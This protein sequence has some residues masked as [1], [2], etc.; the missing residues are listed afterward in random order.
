MDIEKLAKIINDGN[1]AIVPTD[2]VYG[3]IGDA[4]NERAIKKVYNI[5]KRKYSKPLIIMVSSLDMLYEYTK[6]IN[7]KEKELINKFWPGKLTILLPK[8]DKVSNLITAGGPLVGVRYANNK[9]L[10]DLMNLINK[11]LISTSAN[12]ADEKTITSIDMLE[13]DIINNVAYIYDTGKIENAS[14]TIVRVIDGK[15]NILR[16]GDLAKQIKNEY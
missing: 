5:K 7:E 8:N 1:L 11:P 2:T 14:S 9:P 16:E 13:E 4:T 3:I 12:L 6:D 10:N 15:V